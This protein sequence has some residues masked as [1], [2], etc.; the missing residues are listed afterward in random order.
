MVPL[1][2][3]L[4]AVLTAALRYFFYHV[5]NTS[6]SQLTKRDQHEWMLNRS[7]LLGRVYLF[8]LWPADVIFQV[9]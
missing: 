8:L 7:F 9:T 3:L 1:V 6:Y 5:E 2:P 4:R